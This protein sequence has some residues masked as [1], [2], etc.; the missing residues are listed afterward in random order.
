MGPP[1][2]FD[3]IKVSTKTVII[4][5]NLNVD[6][7]KLFDTL[8][9]YDHEISRMGKIKKTEIETMLRSHWPTQIPIMKKKDKFEAYC[10]RMNVPTGTIMSVEHENFVRGMKLIA[11]KVK[12][13][14]N[15]K[16]KYFRNAITIVMFIDNKFINFKLPR[17]GKIQMTGVKDDTQ[18]TSCLKYLWLHLNKHPTLFSLLDDVTKLITTIRIVMTN[19]DF[20]LGFTI[21]RENL[22]RHINNN[23]TFYSLL[24]TSF[25]YTGVNIKI[26]FK[27]RN[28]NIA[29]L[30]YDLTND[31]WNEGVITYEEYLLTLTPKDRK[32]ELKKRRNNTFLVFYSGTAIMS[33]MTKEYMKDV[34]FTFIKLIADARHSIEEKLIVDTDESGS[35][36]ETDTDIE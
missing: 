1:T 8:E 4:T 5:S 15:K 31:E 7:E 24:E 21:D 33:G 34:Y 35:D 10:Q 29:T 26:P 13:G 36:Y 2:N 12:G 3:S 32:K 14:V 25:G 28:T 27:H 17:Q 9:I 18:I 11:K 19:I 6:I 20:N 23:T 16:T 30:V 22:D